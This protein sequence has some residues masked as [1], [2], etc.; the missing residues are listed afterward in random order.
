MLLLA[1]G[2]S[3]PSSSAVPRRPACQSEPA[4][5]RRLAGG[6][7]GTLRPSCKGGLAHPRSWPAG[8]RCRCRIA[9]LARPPRAGAGG[10]EPVCCCL[11]P[12][13]CWT[14]DHGPARLD[15]FGRSCAQLRAICAAARARCPF[16]CL[17]GPERWRYAAGCTAFVALVAW[18]TVVLRRSATLAK[19]SIRSG[20]NMSKRSIDATQP[21]GRRNRMRWKTI[22][23]DRIASLHSQS[24]TPIDARVF[25]PH[26]A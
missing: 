14:Y 15:P 17:C 24:H 16:R 3:S 4:M 19:L 8:C 7:L 20:W 10:G 23:S 6:L 12:D 9:G 5:G 18:P 2:F 22:P 25:S 21:P 26:S 13:C 1:G 11:S